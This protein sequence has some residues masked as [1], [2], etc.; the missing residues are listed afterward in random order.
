MS[1]QT[2][3]V[4][5]KT[6][7][8]LSDAVFAKLRTISILS[9]LNDEELRCLEGAQEIHLEKDAVLARQ[10]EIAHYFWILLDGEL[11]VLQAVAEGKEMNLAPIPSGTAFGEVPLLSNTPNL[12]SVRAKDPA[13]L[14]QFD[15]EAFWKLMTSC[16][17]VRKSILGN[18]AMRIQKLQSIAVQQ[19]KMASLGTLAAGLMHE[20]NNPGAAARRAASQLRENLMRLHELSTKF[21]KIDLSNDQKQCIFALQ[22]H[23]LAATQ[24]LRLNSLEQSDAEEALAE[25]ME[26]ANIENAWKMAPTLVSVGIDA[27]E[28]KCAREEFVGPIFS[29]ALSWVAALVSSMQLVGTIE[30]SIGRVSDLVLAVKSYAYEGKGQRQ[31]VDIN[32][33]IHAT[34]I[35]LAHKFREKEIV[36]EKQLALDLPIFQALCSGLNQIWTNLLD[37]AIDAASPQGHIKIRTWVEKTLHG[38]RPE[39]CVSIS[40]NGSGIPTECQAHIFDPF[41]TTKPIGVGTGIGLGIVHRIVEQ[42]GG[43]IHF[44]SEPGST[45]FVVR[46]PIDNAPPQKPVS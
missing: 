1:N 9:T 46:L 35:I 24:P 41:Y 30:E 26:E 6:I 36:I 7:G 29:D 43:V 25:W 16:P 37:N 42:N 19:E 32:N 11:S 13:D 14:L 4:Q 44:A 45:E 10:G 21:S 17:G 23:A 5:T 28:L 31:T 8:N 33:S 40:D 12:V 38:S 18:M 20:L 39:I 34:L 22:D 27:K 2:Q 15:E 3:S